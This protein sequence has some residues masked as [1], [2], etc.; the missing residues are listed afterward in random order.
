M[1]A[2]ERISGG[3]HEEFK[4]TRLIEVDL[5]RTFRARLW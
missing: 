2:V 3:I 5:A 1:A 4:H